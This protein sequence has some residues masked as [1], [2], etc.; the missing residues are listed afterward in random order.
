M[1]NYVGPLILVISISFFKELYD[2]I[3]R[4]KRDQQINN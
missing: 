4:H 1:I 2:D 3:L